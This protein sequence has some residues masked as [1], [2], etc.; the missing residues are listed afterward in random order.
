MK[1]M[2]RRYSQQLFDANNNGMTRKEVFLIIQ[3]LTGCLTMKKAKNV[4]DYYI[5]EGR[6]EGLKRAGRVVTAQSTTTKQSQVTTS[7]QLRWHSTIEDVWERQFA[8][9][10][11]SALWLQKRKFFT[12]NTDESGFRGCEGSVRVLGAVD[13]KKHEKNINDFRDSVTVLCTGTVAGE[14]GPSFF[15]LQGRRR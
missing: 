7:Q 12:G 9:N 10:K 13:R 2:G 1:I 6:M 14:T 8:L 15:C 4:L 11:P 5:R 3:Q